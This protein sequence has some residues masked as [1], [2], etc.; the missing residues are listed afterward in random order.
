ME[1][2][3]LARSFDG[4]LDVETELLVQRARRLLSP[5][6]GNAAIA[7]H[8]DGEPVSEVRAY[9]A[10][11]GL[12]SEERLVETIANLTD[13]VLSTQHFTYIEGRRLV[14][15]WLEVHGQTQ[16]FGRLLAEQQTPHALRSELQPA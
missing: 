10:E 12:V 7:I 3:R 11:I 4:R 14:S 13:A 15:E 8:R 6:L 5:A 9:L 2:Q 1:L 16:G